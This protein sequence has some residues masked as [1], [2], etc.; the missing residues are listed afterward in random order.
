MPG[1]LI[2]MPDLI[3]A[4][5]EGHLGTAFLDVFDPEPLPS[6][7]P[8]WRHP[9]ITVTSHIAGFASRRARARSVAAV[10]A[11]YEAGNPLPNLYCADR[12]Y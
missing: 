5:D 2:V 6:D 7:H 10:L 9:R 12:G 3:A 8:A 11:A 4:L 1:S